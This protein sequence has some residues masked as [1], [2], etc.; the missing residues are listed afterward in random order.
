MVRGDPALVKVLL[1]ARGG[2][3][4][5]GTG[6]RLGNLD[7][8]DLF[9]G[10]GLLDSLGEES[11]DPGLVDEVESSAEDT[12]EEEVE[13]DATERSGSGQ[14]F[15]NPKA[16]GAKELTSGGRRCWWGLQQ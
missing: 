16:V 8:L 2:T 12:G 7:L 15:V 13:E 11:L 10:L 1:A 4:G 9:G 3:G 6:E 5:L 14:T